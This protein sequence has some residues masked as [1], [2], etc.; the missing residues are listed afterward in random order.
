MLILIVSL[1]S[2]GLIYF[3]YRRKGNIARTIL[4]AAIFLV[5][6]YFL[7][8][9]MTIFRYVILFALMVVALYFFI[10]RSKK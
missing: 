2:A 10:F 5:G 4:F 9:V 3:D 1:I 6:I 7:F 8:K